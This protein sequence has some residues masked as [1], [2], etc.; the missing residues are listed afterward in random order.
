VIER[1]LPFAA[2]EFPMAT[3]S[4]NPAQD[5][6]TRQCAHAPCSCLVTPD[7]AVREDGKA[8]CS[9][10]CAEGFGCEHENCECIDGERTTG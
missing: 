6:T 1:R 7:S 4:R 3:S 9:R 5:P 10:G 8:Y 2:G